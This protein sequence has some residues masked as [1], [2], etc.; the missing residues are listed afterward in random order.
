MS[1][2]EQITM[3]IR[4]VYV[5]ECNEDISIIVKEHFVGFVPLKHTTGVFMA[6]TILHQLEELGL[7]VDNLCGQGYDNGSNMKGK[8]N[9]IQ[10]KLMDINL[11]VFFIPCNAHTFNLVAND[12]AR[13]CLEATNFFDLV[14]HIYVLLSGSTRQWEVLTYHV[15]TLTVKPLRETRWESRIDA[16]K[17]LRYGLGNIYDALIEIA[18]DRVSWQYSLF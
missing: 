13:C 6:D 11:C 8:D 2:V 10:R 4:F 7:A 12:D 9:A 5:L 16:L 18:D 15:P 17:P 3:I 1:H 14:Q